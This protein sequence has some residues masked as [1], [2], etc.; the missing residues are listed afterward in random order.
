MPWQGIYHSRADTYFENL[1]DYLAWYK[2]KDAPTVGLLISRYYWVNGTLDIENTLIEALETLGLNV[3]PVFSYSTRDE[4][5]GAKG[6]AQ[7]I[8]EY[9][10]KKDGTACIDA[11]VK[12]QAFF[13]GRAAGDDLADPHGAEAGVGI[14]KELDVPVFQRQYLTPVR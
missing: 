8:Q 13:L 1:E 10:L 11:L 5:V 14:L 4:T 3:I 6:S 7:V 12:L 2:P 9:F